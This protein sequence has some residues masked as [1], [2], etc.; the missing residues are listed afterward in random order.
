MHSNTIKAPSQYSLEQMAVVDSLGKT[1]F[2]DVYATSIAN[3]RNRAARKKNDLHFV[4]TSR[5][6]VPLEDAKRFRVAFTFYCPRSGHDEL[7]RE[8]IAEKINTRTF[9][10]R[11]RVL[12][13]KFRQA[14]RDM[15]LPDSYV[16]VPEHSSISNDFIA[17]EKMRN[18]STGLSVVAMLNSHAVRMKGKAC[19]GRRVEWAVLVEVGYPINPGIASLYV[20]DG[21]VGCIDQQMVSPVRIVRPTAAELEKYRIDWSKSGRKS[22]IKL[23]TKGAE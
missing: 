3:R 21:D 9:Q 20:D 14:L 23:T 2:R 22:R 6:F 17:V 4:V 13:A 10:R 18:R 19:K 1:H 8:Y 12:D 16:C 5:K 15:P 7:T 11:A